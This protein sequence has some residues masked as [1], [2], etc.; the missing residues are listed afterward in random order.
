MYVCLLVL[1][2]MH[3]YMATCM[4]GVWMDR[5][6]YVRLP[7]WDTLASMTSCTY[8]CLL[9]NMA[10]CIYGYLYCIYRWLLG[11]KATCMDLCLVVCIANCI[12][13]WLQYFIYLN[14]IFIYTVWLLCMVSMDHCLYSCLCEWVAICMYGYL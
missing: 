3:G 10:I 12:D 14:F 9:V 2:C 6:L 5:T 7:V 13:R 1:Y 8:V 4:D 11:F